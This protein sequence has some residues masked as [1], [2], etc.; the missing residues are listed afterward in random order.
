M[1]R[2]P[3]AP[4]GATDW[5]FWEKKA[6]RHGR[7]TLQYR[8]IPRAAVLGPEGTA[9]SLASAAARRNLGREKAQAFHSAKQAAVGP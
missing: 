8:C 9:E 4:A 1:T 2:E 5:H 3:T 6:P 7:E